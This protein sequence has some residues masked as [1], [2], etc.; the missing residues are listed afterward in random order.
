MATAAWSFNRLTA[1]RCTQVLV[2][3]SV[4]LATMVPFLAWV[5][6]GG[7]LLLDACWIQHDHGGLGRVLGS[8]Q[9]TRGWIVVAAFTGYVA[10]RLLPDFELDAVPGVVALVLFAL[11]TFY[12]TALHRLLSDDVVRAVAA[13]FLLAVSLAACIHLFEMIS[14]FAIR[15]AVWAW[16][17]LLRP[18]VGKIDVSAGA[19]RILVP[20]IANQTSTVLAALLWPALLLNRL[21]Q[22]AAWQRVLVWGAAGA[23]VAAIA[24]SDQATSKAAVLVG[25]AF[26]LLSL[27]WRGTTKYWLG[28]L[29][30][31][32]TLLVLPGTW[33]LYHAEAYELPLSISARHRIV[34]WG[35]TASKTLQHPLIGIGTGRTPR[36]DDSQKPDVAYISTAHLPVATNLHAH[37]VFLQTWYEGGALGALF[38][39]FAGLPIIAWITTASRAAQPLLAAAFASGVISASFSYSLLAAW[40]LATFAITALFCHFA[41]VAGLRVAILNPAKPDCRCDA[42]P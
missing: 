18:R 24:L 17:P 31:A 33:Y 10:L 14:G 39:L 2:V 29:W 36:F 12:T 9:P 6:A 15:R 3:A 28:A 42:P 27:L 5:L 37:N 22:R 30:V 26:W 35:V 25:L 23:A 16:L 38:L 8:V 40:F 20:Y 21:L 41:L 19:V 1:L 32:S 13:A 34:L 4:L 11:L 7:A